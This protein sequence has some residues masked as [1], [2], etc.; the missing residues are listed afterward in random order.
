MGRA[1]GLIQVK[2]AWERSTA[3]PIVTHQ[4]LE[5][6]APNTGGQKQFFDLV[7]TDRLIDIPQRAILL[8]GGIG[9]GKSTSGAA[10]ACSR[11]LLDPKARGLVSANSYG[12]LVTSTLIALAEFCDRYHV[13]L[14]PRMES[15]EETARAIAN[16]RLCKIGDASV[17][18]LSA[19]AF[20]G[21]TA[22]STEAGRGLQ[23]RW[24]WADEWLYADGSAFNTLN[25]R[26][27]RGEG[28]MKGLGLITSSPNKNN[29]FNWGY[30]FFDSPDR[31]EAKQKIYLSINCPTNENKHLDADYVEGLQSSY[32]KELAAIELGGEYVMITTGKVFG[33]FDRAKHGLSGQDAADFDYDPALPLHVSFDF[34]RHPATCLIAQQR[35]KELFC[36]KEFYL[37]NSDTFQLSIEVCNWIADRTHQGDIFVYG[38]ASGNSRTANSER[39]NWQIVWAE[40]KKRGLKPQCRKRY[41]ESN[42]NV[43]DTTISINALFM[44]ERLYVLVNRCPELLKDLEQMVWKDDQLDKSDLMRSH[45]CDTLRYLANTLFPYRTQGAKGQRSSQKPLSGIAG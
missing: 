24:F 44:A 1:S 32:T 3:N 38:D 43:L 14:F 7:P 16:R 11:A 39:S 31:D 10:F 12:Q 33:Y 30:D 2:Q 5:G 45:L 28:N 36:I 4:P 26:L 25:G 17:L 20:T 35:E 21:R 6:F 15:P 37:L 18:V 22:N 13:P 34:N 42:P 41:G 9:S 8:R 29:P 23:V 27:G 40:L 19:D